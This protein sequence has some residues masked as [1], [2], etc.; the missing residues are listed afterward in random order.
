MLSIKTKTR[1]VKF[2][3]NLLIAY[4]SRYKNRI[5]LAT[6][7]LAIGI[8][9]LI[10]VWPEA[11][12]SNLLAIGYVGSYNLENIPSMPLNLV[13]QPLVTHDNEGKPVP[14]LASHW[15]ITDEGKTYLVF[16]KD[17]LKWHDG[18]NLEAKDIT[19][20]ATGINITAINSKTLQFQLPSPLVSFHQALD[21]PIF[22]K[23]TFY[24]TGEYRIVDI[25]KVEDKVKKISLVP[26]NKDLPPVEIKFYATET[27]A[28]QA[29]KIGEIRAVQIW[30][31][32][33]FSEWPNLSVQKQTAGGEIVTLFFNTQDNILGAKEMRQALIHAINRNDFDGEPATSPIANTSWAANPNLK[34]YD[35]N[36]GRAKELLT[37][38]GYSNQKITVTTTPELQQQAESIQK[39]WQAIGIQADISITKNIPADFQVLLAVNKLSPDPDQYSLWHSTQSKTNITRYKNVKVDKLLEDGRTT[40]EEDKRKELY[41]EFQKTLVEDAP[42]AFL[43]HPYKYQIIYKNAQRLVDQLPTPGVK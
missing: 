21:K 34:R 20:A 32:G 6:T 39:D 24:G 37:K 10:K 30:A 17:N 1:R 31:A 33:E 16:L 29:L 4:V 18:T 2:W 11:T 7:I 40:Q 9:T 38:A 41:W 42:A 14:E 12:K 43:Y 27:Q 8:F 22:K 28:K 36:T 35:Y 5:L 19:I 23:N 3:T 13:T 25:D 26:Q 15:Q